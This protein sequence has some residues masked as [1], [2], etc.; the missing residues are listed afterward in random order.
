[1][2]NEPKTQKGFKNVAAAPENHN[3]VTTF[4]K[5]DDVVRRSEHCDKY[6]ETV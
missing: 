1:M 3:H 2:A 6:L 5:L 4:I